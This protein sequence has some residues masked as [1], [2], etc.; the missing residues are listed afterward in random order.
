VRPQAA[1]QQQH[2]VAGMTS[3]LEREQQGML[4]GHAGKWA[5]ALAAGKKARKAR[6]H[7]TGWL[8]ET[9]AIPQAAEALICK[10][11]QRLTTFVNSI[12]NLRWN[13]VTTGS[14][15]GMLLLVLDRSRL[16]FHS[17]A[18]L[19]SVFQFEGWFLLNQEFIYMSGFGL[20]WKTTH[21]LGR[22]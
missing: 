3:A 5:R 6:I 7:S 21:I 2:G 1:A 14:P 20:K 16:A 12:T 19:E 10:I 22:V 18:S 11:S 4:R 15:E 8:S 17:Q 13:L 9:L